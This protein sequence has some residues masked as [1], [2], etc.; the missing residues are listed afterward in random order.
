MHLLLPHLLHLQPL[1]S[2][3]E[4]QLEEEVEVEGRMVTIILIITL[5][6]LILTISTCPTTP[7]PTTPI[8]LLI[9]VPPTPLSSSGVSP[10]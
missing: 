1:P 7:I 8:I 3:E 2:L 5:I 6:I 10:P 4:Q 9:S